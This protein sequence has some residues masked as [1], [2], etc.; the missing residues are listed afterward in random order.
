MDAANRF[1]EKRLAPTSLSKTNDHRSQ[2]N[3]VAHALYLPCPN[4]S[5]LPIWSVHLV[6]RRRRGTGLSSAHVEQM[7]SFGTPPKMP[8]DGM[9]YPRRDATRAINGRSKPVGIENNRVG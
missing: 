7:T 6:S 2:R 1:R 3:S 9:P 4:H 5:G 8:S